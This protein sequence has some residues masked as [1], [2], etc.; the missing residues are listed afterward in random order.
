[1]ETGGE[2]LYQWVARMIML[3]LYMTGE[4]PFKNVYIHGYVLAEDKQKMSKSVGNVINPSESIGE[5]GSDALRMGLLTGRRPGVNQGFHPAKIKAG[6]NFGNK[7][8]NIAR[9]VEDKVGDDHA[10]RA[11]PIPHTPA[12]HWMLERLDVT[13]KEISKAFET[14]R[15]S[16]AYELLY[17]F[18][19]H[20]LADWYVE[21]S[22]VQLNKSVLAYSLESVL[23]LAHPFAPFLTETIWQTLLWENDSLLAIQKWPSVPTIDVAQAAKFTE[24]MAV[25]SEARQIS[26]ALGV[27]KPTLLF[28]ESSVLTEQAGLLTHLAHLGAANDA[29]EASQ[30][31]VRLTGTSIECWLAIDQSIARSYLDRLKIQQS[32]RLKVVSNLDFRLNNQDYVAKA[33]ANLVEQTRQQLDEEHRLL[34]AVKEEI[35][36]FE[37]AII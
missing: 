7:L 30:K 23:K 8:W 10:L 35:A 17:H 12:D 32:Q 36:V 37:Q 34:E 2:I 15:L 18:V 31:G 27:Q 9:L 1:M 20:D 26:S 4:G 16:E 3:G 28:K 14:Y 6:R 29:G 19:W 24:V 33:P 5:Y 25:A 11:N 21:A 22:K 13:A